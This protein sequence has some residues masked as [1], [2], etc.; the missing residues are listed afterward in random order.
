MEQE[1]EEESWNTRKY[2]LTKIQ[3]EVAAATKDKPRYLLAR[4][5]CQYK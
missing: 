1:E 3:K 5:S 2:S 4:G